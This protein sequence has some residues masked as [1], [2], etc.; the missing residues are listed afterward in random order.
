M[1][2]SVSS[3]DNLHILFRHSCDILYDCIATSDTCATAAATCCVLLQLVRRI[4]AGA[5][6]HSWC[7]VSRLLRRAAAVALCPG[8]CVASQLLRLAAT[9]SPDI[10]WARASPM[11]LRYSCRS[12][13]PYFTRDV[14][15]LPATAP[16]NSHVSA[17]IVSAI[18]HQ[19]LMVSSFVPRCTKYLQCI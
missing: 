5:P 16:P 12:V 18:H 7:V 14:L 6:C 10:S 4:T 1:R 3:L 8:C 13:S 11:Q 2:G 9:V 19:L 17:R 15:P